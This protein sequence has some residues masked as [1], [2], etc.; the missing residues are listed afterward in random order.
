MQ[1]D[2]DDNS[3]SRRDLL[4]TGATAAVG[5]AAL[6]LGATQGASA[7]STG[8]IAGRRFKAW[9]H[10]EI[11]PGN[12][13]AV[14]ELKLL[15]VS[16]RQVVVRTEAT[17]CCYSNVSRALGLPGATRIGLGQP[18][19][20]AMILGHGGVGVVEAIGPQV[21]RVRIGDRVIV[22]VTPQCGECFE[23]MHQR[24]DRC[25]MAF[26]EP[27][28]PI[29]ELSDGG[30]VVQ[31]TN[32]GGHAE[33]MVT[34]EEWVAPIFSNHA[35]NELA[36]LSCVSS[37]GLGMTMTLAPI[38]AGSS[39]V[40]FGAG[41]VGLSAVQGARIRGATRIIA[42]EPIRARRELALKLGAT[43]ALDPNAEGDKLLDRLRELCQG[44]AD[45]A[46]LGSRPRQQRAG[47][48]FVVEAVGGDKVAPKAEVGPDPTGVTALRQSWE[49]C[50]A[51]GHV[52]TC[53]IGQTGEVSFPAALWSNGSK[54][55]HSS[56]FGGTHLKR[57]MPRYTQLLEAGLF[58]AKSLVTSVYR[59]DQLQ[60][61]FQAVADRTTVSSV[62]TFV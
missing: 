25:Q 30:P 5:G 54:T 33:L 22:G 1:H 20:E 51:A 49:I 11:A 9:V 60:E 21:K 29:A 38:E 28:H 55:H 6:L 58:D 15:P 31:S 2:S 24:A 47:A 7:K 50:R 42:V 8:G 44:E 32:I 52:L 59:L 46:F 37:T 18:G 45:N 36:M 16:G 53:G 14:E 40:V 19:K 57:D 17:Q 34:P 62:I 56:Q 12:K 39:V 23:C 13:G 35:A 41:P 10:R 26:A 61:A 43:A 27:N 4:K 3:L 48:D